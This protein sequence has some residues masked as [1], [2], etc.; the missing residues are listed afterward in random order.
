MKT[1]ITVVFACLAFT[2]AAA[3]AEEGGHLN[4]K[5]VVQKEEVVTNDAGETTHRLVPAE[6]VVPGDA[7]IY[8]I[9]FTNI[10]DETAEDI[11][12]TNPISKDL[13]YVEGS[14]FGPGTIVEFSVDGGASFAGPENLVVAVNGRTRPAEAGDITHVRWRMQ[15]Q[16]EAGE[17][18]MAQFRAVLN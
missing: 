7:V 13:T 12:I 10:S 2:T 5:T 14:A 1:L 15:N 6:S 11:V 17:Q 4:V 8:T 9:T 3:V 16:L 18:G